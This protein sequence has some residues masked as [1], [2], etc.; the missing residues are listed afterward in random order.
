MMWKGILCVILI[1]AALGA[2]G[3]GD[4]RYYDDR[5][6]M[7]VQQ[8]DSDLDNRW[9]TTGVV[10]ISVKGGPASAAKLEPGELISYVIGERKVD[11]RG[12]YNQAVKQAMKGDNNFILKL[13]DGRTIRI[14]VRR[15]GDQAGLEV[16]GNRVSK[17]TPGSPADT[18]NIKVGD[19][20]ESV[21]DERNIKKIKD[22]KKATR[23]FAKHDSKVTFRT[24]ELVG[25]KIATINAL[26]NL[27]DVR[28]IDLLRGILES[29]GSTLRQ[30]AAEA[31]ERLV[32][33]SQLNDLFQKFQNANANELP[34]DRLDAQKRESAE[35]LGLL[36]VDLEKNL[37]TLN[38]PFGTQFRHRSEALY[39]KIT[40]GS[41]VALAPK[42]IQREVEPD[43]EIRRDCISILGHLKPTSAIPNLIA[44]MED[45]AEIPGIRFQAGLALSQ[46]G[47][48]AVD[49]L[50]AAFNRGEASVKDIAASALGSIGGNKSRNVLIQALDTIADP[51][52]KLTVADAIAKIGDP[53]SIQALRLQKQRLPADSGLGTFLSELLKQL[54]TQSM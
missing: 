16:D 17:V 13:T 14:A 20:I 33:L 4:N 35:I 7:E 47:A 49:F 10:I 53:T 36:T 15:K 18:G 5:L 3:C 29:E 30:P 44:V 22:Y 6:Q 34:A 43:Q 48:P 52:I 41:M 12:S 37:A 42:Y 11:S 8:L 40:D 27:G 32:A 39:E 51:T 2:G 38:D 26:G 45:N 46:I 21:I 1:G 31:L 28:A 54:E 19:I 24:T 23:E 9:S 50:I 25:I